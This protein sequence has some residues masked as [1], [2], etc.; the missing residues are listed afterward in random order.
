MAQCSVASVLATGTFMMPRDPRRLRETH[1]WNAEQSGGIL[2]N[3]DERTGNE[4][5]TERTLDTDLI[6]TH[7]PFKLHSELTQ[8]TIFTIHNKRERDMFREIVKHYT[9][10]Y[11][12]YTEKVFTSKQQGRKMKQVAQK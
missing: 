12:H 4:T 8:K 7:F 9:E 3:R 6:H 1:T 11:L 5:E 2:L 10:N